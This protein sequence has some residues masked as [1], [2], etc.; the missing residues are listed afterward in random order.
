M[1][2]HCLLQTKKS[3]TNFKLAQEKIS[4]LAKSLVIIKIIQQLIYQYIPILSLLCI[5]N[6]FSCKRL[7]EHTFY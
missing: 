4:V 7:N 1:E 2:L 3:N 5:L 6:F